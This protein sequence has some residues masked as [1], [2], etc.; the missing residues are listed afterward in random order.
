VKGH[1]TGTSFHDEGDRDRIFELVGTPTCRSRVSGRGESCWRRRTP[2]AQSRVGILRR[3]DGNH[4]DVT[5]DSSQVIWVGGD[6][7]DVSLACRR[8]HRSVHY[9]TGVGYTAELSCCSSA[10]VVENG[11]FAER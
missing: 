6:H 7:S 3:S 11:H 2:L 4:V 10:P 5:V 9:I 8:H 1:V